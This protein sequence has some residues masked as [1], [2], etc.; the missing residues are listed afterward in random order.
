MQPKGHSSMR[1]H[2]QAKQALVAERQAL[3]QQQAAV[4]QEHVRAGLPLPVSSCDGGKA[5]VLAHGMGISWCQQRALFPGSLHDLG[6]QQQARTSHAAAPCLFLV[7]AVVL[8]VV[9]E[10]FVAINKKSWCSAQ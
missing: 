4:L 1:S 2:M 10:T 5:R 9:R 8:T 7:A 3:L 6:T